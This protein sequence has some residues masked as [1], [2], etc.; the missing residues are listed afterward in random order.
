MFFFYGKSFEFLFKFFFYN[1][2]ALI[3]SV[4][5]M[6]FSFKII[7]F[8]AQKSFKTGLKAVSSRFSTISHIKPNFSTLMI[9]LF[10]LDRIS[11]LYFSNNI[12][13]FLRVTGDTDIPDTTLRVP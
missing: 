8:K 4:I 7:V 10:F 13:Y 5:F 11:L 1:A 6:G 12:T 3:A 9:A 2:A